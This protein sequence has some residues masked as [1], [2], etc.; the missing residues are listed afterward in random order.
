VEIEHVPF[1]P[2]KCL[3]EV[4]PSLPTRPAKSASSSRFRPSP[5][6]RPDQQRRGRL[7]QILINLV[8][9]ALKFTERGGVIVRFSCA[10]TEPGRREEPQRPP[11]F[12]VSDTGVGIPL[13]KQSLLFQPFSQVDTSSKRRR[14][15]TGSA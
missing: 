1:S 14:S 11:V 13:E 3:E 5:T 2:S 6:C 10:R 4:A 9:N 7:R 8:G 12:P 15:G